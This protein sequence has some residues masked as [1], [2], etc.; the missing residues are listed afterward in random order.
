[1]DWNAMTV[2]RAE[3]ATMVGR[4]LWRGLET[5]WRGHVFLY[6]IHV[7]RT[8][9]LISSLVH[10]VDERSRMI[11]RNLGRYLL[12]MQVLTFQA[13]STAIKKRFPTTDHLRTAGLFTEEEHKIY[14]NTTLPVPIWWLPAQWFTGL[15]MRARKEGRIKDSIQ[16]GLILQELLV[17]RG[18]C[19]NMFSY[20][21]ISVPLVYT[22]V[23]TLATYAYFIFQV[24]AQQILDPDK[25]PNRELD[26]F[27]PFFVFLQFLFYIG[28]LKVA[29]QILN[30]YG[31]DDDDF[32]LNWC[33]DR[34]LQSTQLFK[35]EYL[36]L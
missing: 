10:G 15:I 8:C 25:D 30:P 31:E 4:K 2:E 24:M 17:Y 23:V 12:L 36:R 6:I 26:V 20:D 5:S 3:K 22:Q 16:M 14:E 27:F 29:E 34:N 1:M 32:E 11:R 18:L 7:S 35:C 9:L 33:L 13:V 19:G 21:W 28:W